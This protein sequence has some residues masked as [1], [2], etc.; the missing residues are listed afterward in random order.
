[1]SLDAQIA[2]MLPTPDPE[3]TLSAADIPAMRTQMRTIGDGLSR[4][5]DGVREDHRV[6]EM[7][8][9]LYR[10]ARCDG[11]GL[12]VFLHGGGWVF[13]DLDTHDAMTT[14]IA[15]EARCAVLAVGYSLA[16]ERPYPAALDDCDRAFA[17]A[18]ANATQLGLD[19]SRVAIGGESAGANLA[20]AVTLRRRERGEAP[21]LFQCLIH[22]VTDMR[23]TAASIDTVVGP[24]PHRGYMELARALYLGP[25]GDVEDPGVSPLLAAHHEHLPP[26]IVL[27]A[28]CDPLRDDGETYALALAASGVETLVQRLPGL[29]HGFLFLPAEL[30][31]VDRAYRLLGA[32]LRRYADTR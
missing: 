7:P 3:A 17:W 32:L 11:A 13:G 24:G 29:P 2:A 22:P 10:P 12:L 5:S 8:L 21:P 16:P 19:P 23:F 27:T 6:G 1:M 28:E 15:A 26:A 9:R 20:A 30:Q 18:V 31:A 4:P 14:R 25:D